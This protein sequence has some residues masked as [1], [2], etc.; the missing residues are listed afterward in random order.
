MMP[1]SGQTVVTRFA[2]SP[3]GNLHVGGAR[4][5]LFNWA[6]ARRHGGR[7]LLRIEDTDRTRSTLEAERGL[8][9]DLAWLGIDWDN[10]GDEPRQSRRLEAYDGAAE[11]LVAAG[12]AYED[13]GAVRFRM[14]ARDVSLHDEVLGDVTVPEGQIDDFVIRKRDGYP[15]YHLAVVVDDE[16]MGVT[17]VIRGQEHLNNAPKH[18]ALQEALGLGRPVFAHMPLIF[19]PDG[20]KM[21]KRDKAKAARTGALEAGL[22][23]PEGIDGEQYRAFLD[24]KND[25]TRVAEAV[26]RALALTLPE[27]EVA[28]FRRSGYLPEALCNYLALLGWSPGGDRE[29][30]D[31]AFLAERF[32]LDRVVKGPARFDRE[33]LFRFDGEA[34]AALPAGEFLGR[35]RS[36]CGEHQPEFLDALG[37]EALAK[38]AEAYQPRARTLSEPAR[39]AAFFVTPDEEI[40]YAPKAVKKVLRKKEGAGLAILRDLRDRLAGVEPWTAVSVQAE[41]ETYAAERDLGFGAVGQPLRVAVSGATV[42][43]PIDATLDIL[44]KEATLAR[45]G[46]CLDLSQTGEG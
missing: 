29:K 28:D 6:Y 41:L 15:T 14:P 21:G 24:K 2:P 11:R 16:A 5:A 44:G 31:N 26:A 30:F 39:L 19:N 1:E 46:R 37:E 18:V 45:I 17:H 8:L 25:D 4:T 20:S 36:W 40:E 42:S 35:W 43:P 7:F 23:C 33:K 10:A 9:E 3:T 38:L 34:I 27:I 13:E 32:D 12:R 22:A